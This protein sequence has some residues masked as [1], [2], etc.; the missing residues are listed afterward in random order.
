M[1]SLEA[2][3]AKESPVPLNRGDGLDRES[4]SM[5]R[6]TADRMIAGSYWRSKVCTVP[7]RTTWV[8]DDEVEEVIESTDLDLED[9]M[10]LKFR[11]SGA[12]LE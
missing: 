10:E 9:W 5:E 8:A 1:E 3:D 7:S 6:D 4:N 12:C 11:N 2:D